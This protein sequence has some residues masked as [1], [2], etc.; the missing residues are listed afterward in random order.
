M[1]LSDI[2]PERVRRHDG[3]KLVMLP[4]LSLVPS[5]CER[6]KDTGTEGVLQVLRPMIQKAFYCL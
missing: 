4:I 6:L 3:R 1:E 2:G 5:I